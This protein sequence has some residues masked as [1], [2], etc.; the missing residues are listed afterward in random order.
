MWQESTTFSFDDNNDL[1]YAY[2]R[3]AYSTVVFNLL[4]TRCMASG[5]SAQT[6]SLPI[7][8]NLGET[9]NS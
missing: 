9:S 2:T 8:I 1:T 3:Q 4:K 6:C 7:G 5:G